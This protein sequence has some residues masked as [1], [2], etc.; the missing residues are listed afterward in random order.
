[1]LVNGEG[2][3]TH[4]PDP[5]GKIIAWDFQEGADYVAGD[6]TDAY[7]GK[8]KKYVRHIVFVKPDVILIADEVEAKQP[9]KFQWMLHG[10]TQ[11]EVNESDQMLT[12]EREQAGVNIHYLTPEPLQFRQWSGYEPDIDKD[13]LDSIDRSGFPTQWHLE[14]NTKTSFERVFALTLLRPYRKG[15]QRESVIQTEQNDSAILLRVPSMDNKMVTIVLRKPG[16]TQAS[17][18]GLD[19][20]HVVIARKGNN[21]WQLVR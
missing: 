13:Y 21:K 17:I 4:S 20:T 15:Q 9:S 1:M 10:P 11:F 2:Q 8:L 16:V 3:K 18:G 19:F 6:A 7:E 5:L 14:A 12:L